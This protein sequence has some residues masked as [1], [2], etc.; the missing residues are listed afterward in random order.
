MLRNL[1]DLLSGIMPRQRT[2]SPLVEKELTP[3]EDPIDAELRQLLQSEHARNKQLADA[4]AKIRHLIELA[5]MTSGEIETAKAET[6]AVSAIIYAACQPVT[7]QNGKTDMIRAERLLLWAAW[8]VA[9][10]AVRG[11]NRTLDPASGTGPDDPIVV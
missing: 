3:P 6:E 8:R 9:G 5:L 11:V 1:L 4:F 10:A 7:A 2:A